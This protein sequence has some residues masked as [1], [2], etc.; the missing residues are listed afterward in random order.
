MSDN[1]GPENTSGAGR[2]AGKVALLTGAASGI[3]QATAIRM[4]GEGATVWAV[5]INTDGLAETAET[6]TAAG[7]MITTQR[8]DVTSVD[9]CKSAV[10]DCVAAHGQLD[11]LGNIAG[12]ARQ[13]QLASVTQA[14]WDLIMQVN[15]NGPFFLTQAA[16]PHI[17]ES[18]GAVI[19]LASS[20]GLMGQAYTV[21]YCAAKGAVVS[22]TRALAM[23][24]AQ[25][26]VRINA[27]APG[28]VDTPLY[29][30]FELADG[31][32]FELMRNYVGVRPPGTAEQIAG[33]FAFLAS[34]DATNI[35]G[36]ILS[37]DAGLTAA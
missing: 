12:V 25:T 24:F 8:I 9:D 32:D 2:F 13:H 11:V 37:A 3:G 16:M 21:P 5:D 36:S 28:A 6:V 17:L 27:I 4:A 31:I 35:H 29:R 14:D 22:M 20:A 7:G 15:V 23:E 18:N 26:G 10:A 1:A 34:D 19:L 30:N 33:L